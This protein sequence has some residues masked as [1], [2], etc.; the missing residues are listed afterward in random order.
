MMPQPATNIDVRAVLYDHAAADGEYRACIGHT[1]R[2][3]ERFAADAVFREQVAVDPAAASRRWG[4]LRDPSAI[5]TLWDLTLPRTQRQPESRAALRYQAYLN[6]KRG[7]SKVLRD[8][9][10]PK[11]R[12]W[13]TW[14]ERQI[15]RCLSHLGGKAERLVHAP[16]CVELGKG[17][18]LGCGF[19]AV[20][21]GRLGEQWA[22]TPENK[23]LWRDCLAVMGEILGTG[24]RA[25][26]C[27]WATD[28]MDNPDYESFLMDFRAV[29]GSF[30][31]TT[32]AQPE[33]HVDRIKQLLHL[34]DENGGVIERFSIL[35]LKQWGRVH[36]EFTAEE[37]AFVEC[38]PQN[39]EALDTKKVIAGRARDR[40]L[41]MVALGKEQPIEEDLSSTIACVSGFYLNMVDRSVQLITP[42]NANARWPLGH[43]ILGKDVFTDAASL[44]RILLRMIDEHMKTRVC[45]SD[46]VRFREDLAYEPAAG[47]FSVSTRYRRHHVNLH[48]DVAGMG[49]MIA[50]GQHT[51][52]DIALAMKAPPEYTMHLLNKALFDRGLLFE[53]PVQISG[54]G[55]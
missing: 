4:L 16:Y 18:S 7:H 27:Y 9:G 12:T 19:C 22:Y 33:K 46:P 5:R 49:E 24:A 50:S 31:Q 3:L 48:P 29:Q 51:A 42:C 17:C 47:G 32:T 30:P 52:M 54:E 38:V 21:A 40:H 53:E 2:F 41:K 44:R 1:K 34:S 39:K 20:A 45:H 36:D 35:T 11:N 25:G 14:R 8:S 37:M 43:W 26:Y 15:A 10:T 23:A 13:R 6:E 55:L 28:P